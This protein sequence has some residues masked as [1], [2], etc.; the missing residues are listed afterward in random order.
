METARICMTK[1]ASHNF[2][3]FHSDVYSKYKWVRFQQG[4]I[5][6]DMI[7]SYLIWHSL[8][9]VIIKLSE[10]KTTLALGLLFCP[11]RVCYLWEDKPK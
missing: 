2:Y 6:V 7:L 4:C 9:H 10:E 3:S 8:G 1:Q 5:T 11:R